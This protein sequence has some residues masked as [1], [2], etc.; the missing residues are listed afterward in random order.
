SL[1]RYRPF[2]FG[3]LSRGRRGPHGVGNW[4]RWRIHAAS[5]LSLRTGLTLAGIGRP[6]FIESARIPQIVELCFG[7]LRT[8]GSL[9]FHA[10]QSTRALQG[11][12]G[13]LET[14]NADLS[15]PTQIR[16]T[17]NHE[18]GSHD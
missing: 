2:L 12:C 10:P 17:G 14:I 11:K 5:N 6:T 16:S 4:F 8:W 13:I 7:R 3:V 1:C 9:I 15:Y 18:V